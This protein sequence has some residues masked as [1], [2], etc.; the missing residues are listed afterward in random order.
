VLRHGLGEFVVVYLHRLHTV[1]WNVDE[2]LALACVQADDLRGGAAP[3]EE[4][5]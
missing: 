1:A 5:E 3:Y 2:S 4:P